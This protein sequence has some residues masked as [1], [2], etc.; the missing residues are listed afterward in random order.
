MA[1][2]E[3]EILAKITL[4]GFMGAG[5]TSVGKELARRIGVPFFDSDNLIEEKYGNIS[6]IFERKGEAFFRRAEEETV[7]EI[8]RKK[9]DFVLSLGGGAILSEKIRRIANAESVPI[10]LKCGVKTAFERIKG[11]G[12]PLAKNFKTFEKLFSERKELYESLPFFANAEE[13]TAKEIASEI[14]NF[15]TPERFLPPYETEISVLPLS[16]TKNRVKGFYITDKNVFKLYR[17]L[18]SGR[19]GASI[20]PGENSKTMRTVLSIYEKLLSYGITRNDFITY[21][22][23]G[24]VGDVAGFVSATLLRGV[25]LFAIPTTLLSMTDSAIGGKNG[26]NLSQGKNLAGTFYLP[27]HTLIN[28]IFLNTLSTD[29][30]KNGSGEIFKYALLSENGLF[31]IL[32]KAEGDIFK[33]LASKEII[34]KSVKEKIKFVE[35]DPFDRKGIRAFL[36]LG[37]TVGHAVEKLSSFGIKHGEAVAFG[38]IVSAFYSLKNGFLKKRDYNRIIALYK[39]MGFSPPKSVFSYEDILNAMMFDKKREREAIFWI[40]P[41]KYNKCVSVRTDIK[42]IAKAYEEVANE[43]TRD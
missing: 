37:H 34:A 27:K 20:P 22:G 43:N 18:F 9:G 8:L 28:P 35:K 4:F 1:F 2:E 30:I 14:E 17:T 16:E 5:K 10:Y 6:R 7:S 15:L 12:R 25:P 26:V 23:G 32:E 24:V 13:K 3:E 36:N 31:E 33:S 41:V 11:G 42:D 21:A 38:I 19:K 39:K 29:E 40:V